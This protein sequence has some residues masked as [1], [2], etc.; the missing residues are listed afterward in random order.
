MVV[1][2]PGGGGGGVDDDGFGFDGPP[3]PS[4]HPA[5]RKQNVTVM[6]NIT[7]KIDFLFIKNLLK[8]YIN[9]PNGPFFQ[10]SVFGN[11]FL[12]A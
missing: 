3:P 6:V 5:S 2:V 7:P 4:P 10:L 1:K 12:Q 11:F 9:A 8:K